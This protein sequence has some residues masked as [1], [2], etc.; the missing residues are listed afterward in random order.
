MNSTISHNTDGIDIDCSVNVLVENVFYTGNDDAI[1]VKS[2]INYNGRTF[3]R[4]TENVLV[5]N[6]TVHLS[7]NNGGGLSIGSEMSGG[8]IFERSR[9]TGAK[10]STIER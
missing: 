8:N 3:G 7:N 2:G 1:A 5:R 4:T 9:S 10:Y 6:M